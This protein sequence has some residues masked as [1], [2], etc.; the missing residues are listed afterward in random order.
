MKIYQPSHTPFNQR[1]SIGWVSI[2]GIMIP[3][4]NVSTAEWDSSTESSVLESTNYEQIEVPHACIQN[5]FFGIEIHHQPAM[6]FSETRTFFG[7]WSILIS[8]F[9][10]RYLTIF[11][12]EIKGFR[13]SHMCR[14]APGWPFGVTGWPMWWPFLYLLVCDL[15]TSI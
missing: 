11:A 13:R 3:W 9:K 5:K 7:T 4:M 14:E 8:I 2:N 10:N 1:F 6:R 12:C 15:S